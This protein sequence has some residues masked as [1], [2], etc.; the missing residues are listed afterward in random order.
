MEMVLLLIYVQNEC[1][2]ETDVDMYVNGF[3]PTLMDVVYHWSHE[4]NFDRVCEM[5]DVFEGSIVRAIRRLDEVL[6]QLAAAC[7]SVGDTELSNKCMQAAET[8][9]HGIIAS[10]SLWL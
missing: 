6:V 8:L 7:E 1:K 4:A 3:K 10:A 2:I 9:R 5:T